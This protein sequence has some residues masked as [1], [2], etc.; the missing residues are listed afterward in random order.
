MAYAQHPPQIQAVPYGNSYPPPGPH[1]GSPGG[2]PQGHSHVPVQGGYAAYPPAQGHAA[3][4]PPAQGG[5]FPP[6]QPSYLPPAQPQGQVGYSQQQHYQQQ[7]QQYQQH[8]FPSQPPP[9]QLQHPP[10]PMPG[11]QTATIIPPN[12]I[13]T[14]TATGKNQKT[15]FTPS[16]SAALFTVLHGTDGKFSIHRGP[17]P[18]GP[19]LGNASFN[20]YS[21]GKVDLALPFLG[22]TYSFRKT[23]SSYTN[24]GSSPSLTW[25]IGTYKSADNR[26]IGAAWVLTDDLSKREIA[27]F[28]MTANVYKKMVEGELEVLKE[29][30]M[31]A[32][33][34][35]EAFVTL[36]A[37]VERDRKKEKRDS[38]LG[39]TWFWLNPASWIS[40]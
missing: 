1:P 11:P 6:G 26:I 19:E 33:Q 29:G 5:Y 23:F 40:A 4:P 25:A 22:R 37:E 17:S 3:Y 12:V 30:G 8:A 32:D 10:Q 2:P 21:G 35:E 27:R 39:E 28:K 31:S 24:L 18:S 9:H 34:F 16:R 20:T 36:V 14:Y 7:H 15:L 38:R 13:H